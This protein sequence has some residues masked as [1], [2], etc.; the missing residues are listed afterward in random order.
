MFVIWAA[1]IGCDFTEEAS[2]ILGTGPVRLKAIFDDIAALGLELT[3]GAVASR[4]HSG[5]LSWDAIIKKIEDTQSAFTKAKY[6]N[7]MGEV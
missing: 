4:I 3:I 2:G 1:V 5:T 6:Y 7:N